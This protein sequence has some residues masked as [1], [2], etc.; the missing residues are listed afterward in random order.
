MV[1]KVSS[2]MNASPESSKI[3][4]IKTQQFPDCKLMFVDLGKHNKCRVKF[5]SDGSTL[6]ASVLVTD[7]NSQ[8]NV[9]LATMK[10]VKQ[11][12]VPT[13]N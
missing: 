11:S 8:I 5:A 1:T 12:N 4:N 13:A 2:R 10:K 9:N 7:V 3:T 6:A